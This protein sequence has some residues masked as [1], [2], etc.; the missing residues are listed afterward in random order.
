[1]VPAFPGF[2][3]NDFLG[4]IRKIKEFRLRIVKGIDK[5]IPPVA[6]MKRDTIFI[7]P[8]A[9]QKSAAFYKGHADI[10]KALFLH[11][12]QF[13]WIPLMLNG[14]FPITGDEKHVIAGR[15]HFLFAGHD[16]FRYSLKIFGIDGEVD[17]VVPASRMHGG[18]VCRLDSG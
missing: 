16:S 4:F 8:D 9:L 2:L 17:F 7:I 13:Q 14:R 5:R 18:P 11:A 3:D 1:M 10:L 15:V 12:V 6:V